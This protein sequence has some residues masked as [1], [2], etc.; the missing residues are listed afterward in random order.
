MGA[1]RDALWRG[2]KRDVKHLVPFVTVGEEMH[3]GRAAQRL[4]MTGPPTEPPDPST[5]EDL[6]VQLFIRGRH[7]V[8]LTPAG[9]NFLGEARAVLARTEAVARIARRVA[10]GEVT[11]CGWSSSKRATA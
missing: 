7:G 8:R 2:G 11:A 1:T 10:V 6:G 4:H 5:E 9:R 3:F